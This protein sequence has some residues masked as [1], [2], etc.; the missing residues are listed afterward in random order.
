MKKD[1]EAFFLRTESPA[2]AENSEYL[3][4]RFRIL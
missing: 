1:A 4:Y 2:I 3:M